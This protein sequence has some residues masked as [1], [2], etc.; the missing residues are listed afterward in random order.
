VIIRDE[1]GGALTVVVED[2]PVPGGAAADRDEAQ[3]GLDQPDMAVGPDVPLAVVKEKFGDPKVR[4]LVVIDPDG[5][6]LGVIARAELVPQQPE[7]DAGG[8]SRGQPIGLRHLQGREVDDGDRL[9]A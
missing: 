9:G 8:A 1:D 5:R 6:V 2:G 7:E 3:A 4:R